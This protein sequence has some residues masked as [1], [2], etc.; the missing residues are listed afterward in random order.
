[1]RWPLVVSLVLLGPV[2]GGC[3]AQKTRPDA[4]AGDI[5]ATR[6]TYAELDPWEPTNRKIHAFNRTLDK[7]VMRP[8]ARTYVR[9]VPRPARQGVANFFNNLQQPI[10]A[11]NL[12]A[13]GEPAKSGRSLTRF[14]LNATP[15]LL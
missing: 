4:P 1:M 5:D 2:L 7:Y 11:V 3:H 13:Q 12:L 15:R 10:V 8:V 9:A 14:L 6:Q